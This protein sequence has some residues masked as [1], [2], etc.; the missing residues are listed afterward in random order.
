MYRLRWEVETFYKTAKSGLGLNEL[1]FTKPHV[2]EIFVRAAL[3]RASVAMQAKQA[4]EGKLPRELWLNPGQWLA[5]WRQVVEHLI[6]KL[7]EVRRHRLPWTWTDLA[8]LATDPNRS[9]PPMRHVFTTGIN[10][11]A[12]I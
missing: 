7:L 1:A 4:A 6:E 12:S 2:I 3:L 11:R 5:V 9:R 8:F 10:F